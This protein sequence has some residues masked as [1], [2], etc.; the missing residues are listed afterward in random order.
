[1][2]PLHVHDR[3]QKWKIGLALIGFAYFVW[4]SL[5]VIKLLNEILKAIL[6]K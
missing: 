2:K 3:S 5:E 4:W 6:S 1:M